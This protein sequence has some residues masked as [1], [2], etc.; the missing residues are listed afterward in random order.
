MDFLQNLRRLFFVL[1]H[2]GQR[3]PKTISIPM[4]SKIDPGVNGVIKI[5]N[6]MT[7][8]MIPN[9]FFMLALKIFVAIA[10]GLG[11]APRLRDS[12]SRCLLL[13]DPA[14]QDYFT[15]KNVF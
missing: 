10:A 5:K 2:H 3:S 14:N 9:N 11:F 12:E 7:I 13:A 6:P 15:S 1:F 8:K 4:T